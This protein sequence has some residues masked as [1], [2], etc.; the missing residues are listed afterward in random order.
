MKLT[1]QQR[2]ERVCVQLCTHKKFMRMGGFLTNSEVFDGGEIQ[3][4]GK[5]I[6]NLN[7][8]LENALSEA[9]KNVAIADAIKKMT[10]SDNA[11]TACT[12]GLHIY[13]NEKFVDLLDDK[14]LAFILLHECWHIA[15]KHFFIWKE[16]HD[17]DPD[18][19]NQAMDYVINLQIV[20]YDPNQEV[21]AFP[22]IGGCFD[23]RFEGMDTKQVFDILYK[24]KQDCEDSEDGQGQGQGQ[25]QEDGEDGQSQGQSNVQVGR[26][27]NTGKPFDSHMWGVVEGLDPTE[28][29][30]TQRK[31]DERNR[32]GEKLIQAIGDSGSGGDR[33]FAELFIPQINPYDMLRDYMTA[34]MPQRDDSTWSKPNKRFLSQDIYMPSYTC[35]TVPYVAF[36]TDLSG[37][38]GQDEIT[39]CLTETDNICRGLG[40]ERIDVMYWDTAMRHPHEVYEGEDVRDMI[41]STKPDGGGGT[42]ISVVPEYMNKHKLN[43]DVLIV[44]TDGYVG[45]INKWCDIPT[46]FIVTKSG[47]VERTMKS[48]GKVVKLK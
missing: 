48:F 42:D 45:T 12:D 36:S 30:D 16:L 26:G 25:G 46:I 44:L 21:C 1:A 17:I 38:M 15:F 8:T 23:R 43:P 11:L 41:K 24:E 35:E 18:L 37:S 6:E 7:K 5:L 27:M 47:E 19:T 40:I 22:K 13:I 14:E 3:D 29:L 31:V 34:M 9:H 28:E 2:V 4:I 32:H 20:N 10:E 33:E 39:E